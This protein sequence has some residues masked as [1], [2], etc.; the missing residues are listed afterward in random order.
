MCREKEIAHHAAHGLPGGVDAVLVDAILLLNMVKETDGSPGARGRGEIIIDHNLVILR[1]EDKGGMRALALRRG[2]DNGA[3]SLEESVAVILVRAARVVHEKNQRIA[4]RGV[5]VPGDKEV[6]A[7]GNAGLIVLVRKLPEIIGNED[8][9]GGALHPG[10]L[11]KGPAV[12]GLHRKRLPH[13]RLDGEGVSLPLRLP[14][15][16][17][18][19]AALPGLHACGR[20]LLSGLI[21]CAVP[22]LL[23][24]RAKLRGQ[25]H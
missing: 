25:R 22:L 24:V 19:G 20:C 12:S 5:V 16:D 17:Y 4:L 7:E 14:S 3:V 9:R 10:A 21:R 11:V 13:L 23:Q 8:L 15:R 18:A 6:I 2:P 1:G